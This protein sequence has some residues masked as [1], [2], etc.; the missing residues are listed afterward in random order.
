MWGQKNEVLLVIPSH[1]ND[2][3]PRIN[4]QGLGNSKSAIFWT[5]LREIESAKGTQQQSDGTNE[6][7]HKDQSS[8][9]LKVI[10]GFHDDVFWPH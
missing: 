3:P 10:R 7:Q 4:Q 5:A 1:E 6:C 9:K 8:A 2:A